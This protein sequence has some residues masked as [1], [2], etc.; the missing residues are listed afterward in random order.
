MTSKRTGKWS[1][2]RHRRVQP[3]AVA[4][5]VAALVFLAAPALGQENPDPQA[6]EH[7][8]H[9]GMMVAPSYHI[10]EAEYTVPDIVLTDERGQEVPSR[11][12][13]AANGRSQSIS[14]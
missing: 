1:N 13:S 9:Q 7:A 3:G 6:D 10:V 14:Y 8:A 4:A 11:A 12:S 5:L 2:G